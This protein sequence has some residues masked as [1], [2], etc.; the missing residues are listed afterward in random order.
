MLATTQGTIHRLILNND[1]LVVHKIIEKMAEAANRI[2]TETE[3]TL[4]IKWSQMVDNLCL[5]AKSPTEIESK[6][7]E[8]VNKTVVIYFVS[9]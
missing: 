5:H 3:R 6:I 9:V 4:L 1:I 7:I 8:I 2:K